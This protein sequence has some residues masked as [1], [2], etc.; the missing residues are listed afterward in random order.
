MKKLL[1][2]VV[3]SS[4]AIGMVGCKG[5]DDAGEPVAATSGATTGT[6]TGTTTPPT[7]SPTKAGQPTASTA[8]P[9]L[10]GAAANDPRWKAGT[11]VKGDGK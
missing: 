8:T 3:I 6:G 9:Q 4:F 7:A 2:L 1:L 5:S 11:M 10:N